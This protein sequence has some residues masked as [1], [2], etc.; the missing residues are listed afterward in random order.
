MERDAK[1]TSAS[2]A[3]SGGCQHCVDHWSRTQKSNLDVASL[4][5][6]ELL[7]TGLERGQRAVGHVQV[8]QPV[9]GLLR[10]V[11]VGD[12][13]GHGLDL[14]LELDLADKLSV[15]LGE[16]LRLGDHALDLLRRQALARILHHT[17]GRGPRL[18]VHGPDVEDAVGI[19]GEGD[20]N[21]RLTLLGALDS[22]DLETVQQVV[23]L[24]AWTFALKDAHIDAALVVLAGRV[25]LCFPAWH[26]G[27]TRDDDA[28]DVALELDA[29]RE[30]SD[31]HEH[32]VPA[33]RVAHATEDGS[34]HGCAKRHGL[35]GINR[36][37]ELAA[38]EKPAEHLLYL[39]DPRGAADQDD[40]V[41]CGAFDRGVL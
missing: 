39:G 31:V 25:V 27:V 4:G 34:L 26:R 38:T 12:L 18:L 40:I 23:V 24:G 36:T 37:A 17:L 14:S 41:D 8:L 6:A 16:L 11:L 20:L 15:V 7:V 21:L 29:E 35:V 28:H 2:R 9:E 19:E 5:L 1:T 13:E 33:R 10:E 3:S 32:N 22:L 30:R